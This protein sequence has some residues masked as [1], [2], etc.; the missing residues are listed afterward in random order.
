MAGLMGTDPVKEETAFNRKEIEAA[1]QRQGIK[2][3][4][5]GASTP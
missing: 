4:E 2:A 3:I 1:M 5:R